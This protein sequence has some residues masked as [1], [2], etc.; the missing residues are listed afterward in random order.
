MGRFVRGTGRSW[1]EVVRNRSE[2][3]CLLPVLIVLYVGAP[4]DGSR[5]PAWNAALLFGG[6][7]LSR[8]GL[9]AFDL[10]QLKELQ[11]ALATHARRNSL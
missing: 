9:W 10:C 7:M 8:V 4:P 6:M 3:L 11:L 2:V 5:A 1:E